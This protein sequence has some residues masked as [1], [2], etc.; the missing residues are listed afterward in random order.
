MELFEFVGPLTET[1]S[2]PYRA[3]S[4]PAQFMVRRPSWKDPVW[5]ERLVPPLFHVADE[6]LRALRKAAGEW[7]RRRGWARAFADL[8]VTGRLAHLHWVH[9]RPSVEDIA[10]GP[11]PAERDA[12]AEVLA[13]ADRVADYLALSTAD[14]PGSDLCAYLKAPGVSAPGLPWLAVCAEQDAPWRPVNAFASRHAVRSVEVPLGG[15]VVSVR[16][17][18]NAPANATKVILLLHGLGSRL[19]EVE[20]LADALAANHGYHVIAPDFPGQG[21]SSHVRPDSLSIDV[22]QRPRWDREA[23]F[24]FLLRLDEFVLAFIEKLGL[25][26]ELVALGGGSLGGTIALRLAMASMPARPD[27]LRYLAWS[28]GSVWGTQQTNYVN[29]LG[30]ERRLQ[31]RL[32]EVERR[33]EDP[34]RDNARGDSRH[35]YL[36]WVYDETIPC[37]GEP[38]ELWY[39]AGMPNFDAY[40]RESRRDR[41]EV[42]SESFRRWT[43]GLAYEQTYY[44]ITEKE[45]GEPEPRHERIRRP[46]LLLAGQEDNKALDIHK[47]VKN[48]AG[49]MSGPGWVYSVPETGHSFHNERPELLGTLIHGFLEHSF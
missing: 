36:Y 19:E 24:A 48:L 47:E 9:H 2:V 25:G 6:P 27:G 8:A 44:S 11:T 18:E 31:R 20:E 1:P 21:Y 3:V 23:T 29:R 4:A 14:R 22:H 5:D 35:D 40:V 43:L 45:D 7:S 37:S 30:I 17:I 41:R 49:E 12:A 10:S 16:Y 26:D 46:V 28:P 32:R 42:Y 15:E 33:V 38:A 13:Y 34:T 39:R